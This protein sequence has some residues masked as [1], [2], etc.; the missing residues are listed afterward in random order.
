MEE[1]VSL[2]DRMAFACKYLSQTK[3]SE[4]VMLQIQKSV[5]KGDLNGLLL[6]GESQEGINILQAHMD[7]TGDIQTV[8]L[9]AINYF[10][11]ELFNDIRVQ[12]WITRSTTP[13]F[14]F[15][16]ENYFKVF[17]CYNTF[18]YMDCLNSWGFW[19]KRAELEIKIANLRSTSR[20]ARTV[21]LSC[22]FCGKSVSNVLQ[23]DARIRNVSSNVNKVT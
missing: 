20:T 15:I 23:E 13:L 14:D 6:T 7:S 2:A 21:Y 8:A 22:N 11:R 17:V 18:S 5:D 4:Y 1:G 19:E 12:Y 3:L 16:L 9:I 10:H